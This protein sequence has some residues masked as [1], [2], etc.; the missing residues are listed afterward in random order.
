MLKDEKCY[1]IKSRG[2]IGHIRDEAVV[3]LNRMS[4]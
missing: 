2:G 3:V 1:G 4:Y